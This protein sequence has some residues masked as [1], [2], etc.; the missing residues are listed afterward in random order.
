MEML[1]DP[2]PERLAG[3]TIILRKLSLKH[4]CLSAQA[5]ESS[6]GHCWPANNHDLMCMSLGHTIAP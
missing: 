4:N 6:N 2:D 1:T 3:N 5:I